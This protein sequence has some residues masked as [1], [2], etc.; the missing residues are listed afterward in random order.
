MLGL[1]ALA[2]AA[3]LGLP[4]REP[5]PT[6]APGA[7]SC[8]LPTPVCRSRGS[9][10]DELTIEQTTDSARREFTCG[11]AASPA[12]RLLHHRPHPRR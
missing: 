8:S 11:A 9:V 1:C 5:A 10:L 2:A 7:R 3:L 6:K 12:S 4:C